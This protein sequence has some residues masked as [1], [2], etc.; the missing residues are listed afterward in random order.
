VAAVFIF[1]L[2]SAYATEAIGIHALFGAFLAG[3]VMPQDEPFR[4]SI[5]SKIEDL[6][7]I[8]LLP[9]FFVYTG[10]RTQVGLLNHSSLWVSFA[11][12]LFIAI[13]GKFGGSSIAARVTGQSWKDSLSIGALMNTRG[14]MELV[15]LNIGLDLGILSPLIF[16]MMVLMAILTTLFTSPALNVIE[17]W[18]P[19]K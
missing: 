6:S 10:L 11:W 8:L 7:L 15:V 9:L 14:L 3:V 12:I 18:I 13:A 4:K 16:T 1:L 17:R 5:M 19:G 2:L